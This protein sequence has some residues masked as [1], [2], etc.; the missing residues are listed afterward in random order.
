M[1][2]LARIRMACA[3]H[4]LR[5]GGAERIV[6]CPEDLLER[7]FFDWVACSKSQQCVATPPH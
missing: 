7:G 4:D 5:D 1:S 6:L 2:S 3:P